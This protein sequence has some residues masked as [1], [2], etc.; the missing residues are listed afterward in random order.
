[1]LFLSR[2]RDVN[3]ILQSGLVLDAGSGQ[4]SYDW[5]DTWKYYTGI[6]YDTSP[7]SA[8]KRTADMPIDRQLRLS[9]GASY[10]MDSGKVLNGSFT[11]ADYGD[12]R[13]DNSNGG[14]HVVGEY[15]TNRILFFGFSVNW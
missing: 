2:K 11:Y 1:M 4:F 12:A 15:R 9:F 14:G 13:I 8:Y 5:E 6:A 10:T 3:A 7:T